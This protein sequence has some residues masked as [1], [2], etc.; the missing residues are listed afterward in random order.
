MYSSL[1]AGYGSN[2]LRTSAPNA[3]WSSITSD[4]SGRYLAACQN[5]GNIFTSS[6]YGQLWLN[7]TAPTSS[8]TSITSDSS[9]KYLAACQTGP[10]FIYI[11]SSY[12]ISWSKTSANSDHYLMI[13]SESTFQYLAASSGTSCGNPGSGTIMIS[14]NGLLSSSHFITILRYLSYHNRTLS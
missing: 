9:G 1:Y 3:S 2:W 10:G 12:G 6:T 5:P 11:S 14:T 8:W 7:S 13:S 4:S